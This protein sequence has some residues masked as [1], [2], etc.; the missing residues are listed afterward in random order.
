MPVVRSSTVV[1]ERNE[2]GG[3]TVSAPSF[4]GCITQGQT[5]AEALARVQEAITN[6]I[7]DMNVFTVCCRQ[8]FNTCK[9]MLTDCA[10]EA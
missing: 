1:L 3:Y 8:T 9:S 7:G 10:R 5:M 2:S 4:D 6:H